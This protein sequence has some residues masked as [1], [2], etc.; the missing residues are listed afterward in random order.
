M[1]ASGKRR[2][3]PSSQVSS[4]VTAAPALSIGSRWF[5]LYLPLAEG[6]GKVSSV[7]LTG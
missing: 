1:A 2:A 4:Y 6:A 3:G 7:L 5:T